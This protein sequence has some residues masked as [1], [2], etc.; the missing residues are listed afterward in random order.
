MEDLCNQS[1]NVRNSDHTIVYRRFPMQTC[2]T[3]SIGPGDFVC[4]EDDADR[5]P[6]QI[7]VD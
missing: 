6:L 3:G 4:L 1:A 5:A 7:H 2:H